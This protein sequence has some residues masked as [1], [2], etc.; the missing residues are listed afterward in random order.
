MAIYSDYLN[1]SLASDFRLLT[2][3]RKTQL[4]RISKLRGGR[5]VLVFAADINSQNP[6]TPIGQIDHLPISD[7]LANLHGDALDLVLETHGGSGESVEEIVRIIRDKYEHVAVIV[8]GWAK[9]AGTI[10]TMAADEILMGPI[11]AL[12]PID[13][14]LFWQGKQF[15]A[16]A[17]LEGLNKIKAD[18]DKTGVLNKAYIPILQGISPGELQSAQNALDF[19]KVLVT[20]WLTRYKFKDW[21][22][23]HSTGQPVSSEEREE[24]AKEIAEQLCD[25]SRWLTHS[26]SIRI[27][28]LRDMRL[29]VTDYSE[30]SKLYN[31]ITR[32]YALLQMSFATNIFK[33]Y[34]TTESQIYKFDVAAVTPAQPMQAQ[35]VE[36][37]VQCKKCNTVSRIQ[38]NFEPDEKLEKGCLP[39]PKDNKFHCPK[40]Q[41][42][43]DL[44]DTRRQL[45]AQAKRAIV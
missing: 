14:Q 25:H 5:D 8:P 11:S 32:Y 3:E 13:A 9:S 29:R 2:E 15:S 31:A 28:D 26:R 39:F 36:L 22:E 24:R 34:E 4:R 27:A 12:G 1:A 20:Q 23:H 45:E 33:V 10:I 7:Q 35:K 44:S 38:A 43:H 42:E 41:T 30:D 37:G 21:T 6:D 19:S 16:E 17:L 18:V 40:C